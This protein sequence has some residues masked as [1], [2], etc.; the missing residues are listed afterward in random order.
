VGL[1]YDDLK[2]IEAHQFL[3]TVASGEQGEPGFSEAL[4]VAG[5]LSAIERSWDSGKW[6]DVREVEP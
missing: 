2:V 6:E 1:G 4:A 5:V 3:Q